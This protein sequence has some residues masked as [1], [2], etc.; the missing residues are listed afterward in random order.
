MGGV[1]LDRIDAKPVGAFGRCNERIA[2]PR[3]ARRIERQRRRLAVL[4]RDRR[5]S[6]RPPAAFTDRYQLPAV[7]R[8]VAGCLAAGV[9]KLD[10][11]RGPGMLAHRGEDRLQRG[12]GGIVV[13]AEA[14]RRDAAD[15][16]DMGR[17]D[18]EH[19]RAGQRERI[20]MREVPVV[21]LAIDGRILAHRGHHDAV[22]QFQ[23]AQLDRGKQGAHE[24][25]FRNRRRDGPLKC[26]Y[27]PPVAQPAGP[28]TLPSGFTPPE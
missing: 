20:D 7:P 2:H 28:A 27:A 3:E 15:R 24:G 17:F 21:R 1:K 6:L 12:F 4:V 26:S 11:H 5:R 13:E 16:L 14:P 9:R 8:R 18:T 25:C 22:G 19:R 23:A 10:R